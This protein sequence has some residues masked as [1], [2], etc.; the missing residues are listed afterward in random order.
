MIPMQSGY[1]RINDLKRNL[2]TNGVEATV[3]DLIVLTP[4]NDPFPSRLPH[5]SGHAR[6]YRFKAC[7]DC[8]A[9]GGEHG[10]ISGPASGI[11]ADY[12]ESTNPPRDPNPTAVLPG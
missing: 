9:P 10:S 3:N 4:Q 6:Y 1:D 11:T 12:W 2:R 5:R 7:L 8:L